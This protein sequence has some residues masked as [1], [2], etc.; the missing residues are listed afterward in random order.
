MNTIKRG[1]KVLI[2]EDEI[3]TGMLISGI[4]SSYNFQTQLVT[5]IKEAKDTLNEKGKAYYD[6]LFFDYSLPDGNSLEILE[7]EDFNNE[8]PTII[9]SAYL[10]ETIRQ[11]FEEQGVVECID[12]PIS[13]EIIRSVLLRH[14][15]IQ[16]N[17]GT[18]VESR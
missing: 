1:K 8:V 14:N 18:N 4:L 7:N 13:N 16:P 10:S 2:L 6:L 9:C 3:D 15:F 17:G 5:S 12:K 11:S